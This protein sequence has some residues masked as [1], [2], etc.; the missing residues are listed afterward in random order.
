MSSPVIYTRA[1]PRWGALIIYTRAFPRWGAL[2]IYTRAFPR[3][4]A[5]IIYTRAF[6]HWGALMFGG[7]RRSGLG[8][9]LVFRDALHVVDLLG[10]LVAPGHQLRLLVRRERP[11]ALAFDAL[12]H[13]APPREIGPNRRPFHRRP[14]HAGGG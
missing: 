4:G 11:A 9:H 13:S 14:L 7:L 3:W 5:L 1:F 2:I 12:L 10:V 8:A 6:P